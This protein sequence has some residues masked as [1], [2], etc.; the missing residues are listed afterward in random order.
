MT[1]ERPAL[2]CAGC[3]KRPAELIGYTAAVTALNEHRED[4]G[5]PGDVT[6]DD[7]VWDEEGT[8]NRTTG[9][10]LCDGCYIAAGMPT[11]PGGWKVPD[12][13]DVGT[14]EEWA[15]WT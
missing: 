2:R 15:D 6:V 14:P 7:Y 5:L 10:F 3:G 11:A 4:N 1:R 8:L 9:R 13:T 12:G